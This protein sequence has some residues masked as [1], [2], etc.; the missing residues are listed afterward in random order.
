MDPNAK[1]I[2]QVEEDGLEQIKELFVLANNRAI[3]GK[4]EDLTINT[5]ICR[6][7]FH[8]TWACSGGYESVADVLLGKENVDSFYLEFDD[9]R[10]GGFEP[11]R[12]VAPGKKV[13]LGLVTTKSPKLEDKET[14]IKR[15]KEARNIFR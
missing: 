14:V 12:K 9:E 7:N 2:F 15:I 5:H 8:S 10:S 6:G 3:E 1:A 11:L 4:P 13:V